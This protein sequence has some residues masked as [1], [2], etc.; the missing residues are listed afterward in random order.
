MFETHSDC[1]RFGKALESTREQT[2]YHQTTPEQDLGIN[3]YRGR[4]KAKGKSYIKWQK[5]SNCFSFGDR[6]SENSG[7]IERGS[8]FLDKLNS[9]QSRG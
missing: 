8:G 5:K 2:K 1:R 9:C 3:E 6:D 4:A 7:Y